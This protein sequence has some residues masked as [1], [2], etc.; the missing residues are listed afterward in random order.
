M[1]MIRT[2]ALVAAA[3]AAYS[4]AKDY[5]RENPAKA[6]ETIDK[7]ESF[8]RGKAGPKYADKV[9]KGSQALRSSLGLSGTA[10]TSSSSSDGTVSR[11]GTSASSSTTPPSSADGSGASGSQGF[12]PAI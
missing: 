5:A 11:P 7:V 4:K 2:A 8:V 12:D 10:S 6:S 3:G 1:K 9:G